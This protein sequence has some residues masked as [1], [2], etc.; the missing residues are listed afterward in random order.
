MRQTKQAAEKRCEICKPTFE[1]GSLLSWLDSGKCRNASDQKPVFTLLGAT[2]NASY[3]HAVHLHNFN[4]RKVLD[5]L[6]GVS[7]AAV[8]HTLPANTG[9]SCLTQHLEPQSFSDVHRHDL[10]H[11]VR[12]SSRIQP[13]TQDRLRTLRSQCLVRGMLS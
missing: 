10:H 1:D 4:A 5:M 7:A 11:D 6:Q 8:F 3:V 13:R 12:L 9:S 2:H